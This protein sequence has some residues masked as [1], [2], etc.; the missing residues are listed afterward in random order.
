MEEIGESRIANLARSL[1]Q[2][3]L[4]RDKK[5]FSDFE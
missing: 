4:Q 5:E 3:V 1:K 2:I